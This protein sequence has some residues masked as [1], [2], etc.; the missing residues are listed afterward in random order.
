[1]VKKIEEQAVDV[2]RRHLP[3]VWFVTGLLADLSI[4]NS[5]NAIFR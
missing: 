1:V 5:E 4:W 2:Y 3:E